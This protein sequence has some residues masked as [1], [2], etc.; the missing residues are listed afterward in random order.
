MQLDAVVLLLLLWCVAVL[1][2]TAL[3]GFTT[4]NPSLSFSLFTTVTKM[5]TF[6]RLPDQWRWISLPARYTP[7]AP[8]ILYAAQ[9]PT[10]RTTL[11]EQEQRFETAKYRR[12]P[13]WVLLMGQSKTEYCK[14]GQPR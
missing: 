12:C 5:D 13:R 7:G 1:P 2:N 8:R 3:V 4:N 14:P 6:P 10:F 9:L 11:V